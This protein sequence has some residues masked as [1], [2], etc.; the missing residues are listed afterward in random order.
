MTLALQALTA[1]AGGGAALLLGGRWPKVGLGIAI[2]AAATTLGLG[3]VAG[4]DSALVIGG[5]TL[6]PAPTIRALSI[7]W[8]AGL[9]LL[10]FLGMVDVPKVAP[11]ADASSAAL[12]AS[13]IRTGAGLVAL[14]AA[15]LA[16]AIDDASVAFAALA[17]GSVAALAVPSLYGLALGRDDGPAVGVTSQALAAVAG[18]G[19]LAVVVAAAS[20]L[21]VGG[22]SGAN[23]PTDAAGH[24]AR[25]LLVIGLAAAVVLRSGAIP[26]HLWAAR[27]V[28]NLSPLALPT[29]LAWGVA[30]FTLVAAGSAATVV[31]TPP[32]E[33]DRWL[34]VIVALASIVFGGLASLLHDDLEHVL[35]YI[36]VGDAGVALLAFAAMRPETLPALGTWTIAMAAIRTGLAGWIAAI[37]WTFGVHRVSE[38]G[39]FARRAPVLWL[40]LAIAIAA[41]IGVPGVAM[42]EARWQLV[43][44]ALPG[45]LAT[46]VVILALSPLLAFG[47]VLV[48]GVGRPSADVAGA[49]EARTGRLLRGRGAWSR[50]GVGGYVRAGGGLLRANAGL[51]VAAISLVVAL[52]GLVLAIVGAG[53]SRS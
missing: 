39:G 23:G 22:A 37:R 28:G 10:G 2:L 53:G 52:V 35:G 50:G 18:A 36:L 27:L 20:Q 34:V 51:G 16:L 15:M 49:P 43:S 29:T 45:L 19:I 44:G 5:S 7:G 25:G 40:T 1:L 11:E 9:L 47:R 6:Q 41:S 3:I 42:F 31:T 13:A 24:A 46:I 48:T 30:A 4:A 26:A 12:A 32:D 17:A 21:A 33:A 8:A 14:A 38:L